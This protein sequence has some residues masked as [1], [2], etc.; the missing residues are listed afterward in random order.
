MY[1][2][3]PKDPICN[4]QWHVSHLVSRTDDRRT[5]STEWPVPAFFHL[6]DLV[7]PLLSFSNF[8][9]RTQLVNTLPTSSQPSVKIEEI[10]SKPFQAPEVDRPGGQTQMALRAPCDLLIGASELVLC[11]CTGT[12]DPEFHRD[13]G[14]G[15]PTGPV[16]ACLAGSVRTGRTQHPFRGGAAV[17]VYHRAALPAF[18]WGC[19]LHRLLSFL[20]SQATL[21]R[22]KCGKVYI[23]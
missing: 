4:R 6:C 12:A 7:E 14:P 15:L 19:G 11:S 2:E 1:F 16:V 10:G 9:K 23:D 21:A 20:Y 13:R 5:G 3:L 18:P 17:R 8:L 22:R